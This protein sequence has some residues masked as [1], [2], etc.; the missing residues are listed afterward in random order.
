MGS[1]IRCKCDQLVHK[2][3]FCG[4]GISVLATEAF[5]DAHHDKKSA[6]DLISDL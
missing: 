3:L 4:T 5:L 1:W 6:N 2:N